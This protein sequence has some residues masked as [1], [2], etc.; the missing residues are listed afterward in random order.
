[1]SIASGSPRLSNNCSDVWPC[2]K[3]FAI[4]PSTTNSSLYF[5]NNSFRRTF[6]ASLFNH[7]PVAIITI[8]ITVGITNP[9][10]SKKAEIPPYNKYNNN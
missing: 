7:T 3:V 9:K 8:A 2:Q 6:F 5:S 4:I 1:L 10:V